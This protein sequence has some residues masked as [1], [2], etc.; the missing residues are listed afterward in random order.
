MAKTAPNR[1]TSNKAGV[2]SLAKKMDSTRHGF[3][4]EPPSRK[5]AG[6][7]GKEGVR[8]T[9]PKRATAPSGGKAAAV[10]K[11]KRVRRGRG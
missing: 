8:A 3:A 7:S 4:T 9:E 2:T 11:M 6:A 1:Q 10:E 5:V